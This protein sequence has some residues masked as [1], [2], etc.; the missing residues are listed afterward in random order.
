MSE[1]STT[2]DLV[3]LVRGVWASAARRDWDA[4][5]RFYAPDAVWDMSPMGL[6]T[7]ED[8]TAIRGLWTDWVGGYQELE[9]DV[10]ALDVG[11]GVVLAAVRQNARPVGSTGRVQAQQA[12]VYVWVNGIVA[13]VTIYPDIDEARAA[14][15]LL[16]EERG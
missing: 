15:E 6:G 2:P 7:Y 13:H 11:N 5:L 1:E 8:A 16:A 10:E 14:A 9:L 3:E 4:I 12:L